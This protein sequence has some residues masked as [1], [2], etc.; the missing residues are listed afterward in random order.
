LSH[1]VDKAI[2][3]SVFT[4]KCLGSPAARASKAEYWSR[5]DQLLQPDKE[6]G[7]DLPG[8][9]FHVTGPDHPNYFLA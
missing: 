5:L 8:P 2:R 7:S 6:Q 3:A 4:N 9:S 1:T